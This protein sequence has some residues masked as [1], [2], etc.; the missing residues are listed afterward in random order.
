MEGD[1]LFAECHRKDI[2]QAL[3]IGPLIVGRG[4]NAQPEGIFEHMHRCL[5]AR[6][7]QPLTDRTRPFGPGRRPAAA[8]GIAQSPGPENG[9]RAEHEG[10][11]GWIL[12]Q[13]EVMRRPPDTGYSPVIENERRPGGP[14][15]Q[16]GSAILCCMASTVSFLMMLVASECLCWRRIARPLIRT[17]PC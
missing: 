14:V 9:A 1:Q 12:V 2:G 17:R 16:R 3:L 4:G 5:G 11:A 7:Q 6:I 8:V 10:A 15:A 13:G